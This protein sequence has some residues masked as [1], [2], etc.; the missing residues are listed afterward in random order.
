M[1]RAIKL[2]PYSKVGLSAYI[3]HENSFLLFN[4]QEQDKKLLKRLKDTS[5]TLT[6]SMLSSYP[7]NPFSRSKISLKLGRKGET[8]TQPGMSSIKQI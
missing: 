4:A 7:S 8:L 3:Q 1:L 6:Y 5:T 2:C